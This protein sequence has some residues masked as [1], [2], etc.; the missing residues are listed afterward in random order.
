ME[1][2]KIRVRISGRN[3]HTA[4]VALPG[5]RSEPGIV[6]TTMSLCKLIEEYKGPR[7]HLDFNRDGTLIGIEILA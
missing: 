5:H 1:Q 7:V 2:Q 6:A 3:A 4:Y